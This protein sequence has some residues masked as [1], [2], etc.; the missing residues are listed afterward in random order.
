MPASH[1]ADILVEVQ[2]GVAPGVRDE[3]DVTGL[4]HALE[5]G[6][7]G[8]AQGGP[9]GGGHST[10]TAQSQHS[11]S[12]VTAQSQRSH[13]TVTAQSQ[14]SHSAGRSLPAEIARQRKT[15]IHGHQ[16]RTKPH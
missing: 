1:K 8:V 2:R 5:D 7:A 3:H 9:G 14:C 15:S 12:A 4:L 16:N 13:S 11:H 6:L 10:V